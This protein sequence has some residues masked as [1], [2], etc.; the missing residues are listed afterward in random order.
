MMILM[1]TDLTGQEARGVRL[2]R[3]GDPVRFERLQELHEVTFEGYVQTSPS[4]LIGVIQSRPSELSVTRRLSRYY[5]TNLRRNPATPRVVLRLLDSIQRDLQNELRY[6]DPRVAEG[7]ST[8]LLEYLGQNGF[9]TATVGYRF[10]QDAAARVNRLTFVINEGPRAV[11]DTIIYLGMEDV[12]PDVLDRIRSNMTLKTGD[13]FSEAAF[14]QEIKNILVVLRNNGYFRARS[15]RPAIGISR[16]KLHDTLAVL[17]EPGTRCRIARIVFEENTNG[18]PS[19]NVSARRR[20]LEFEEGEWYSEEKIART[21]V[22]LMN[23]GAFEI[24]TIDTLARDTAVPDGQLN[25]DSTLTLR[26]FTRN[27]KVYDVGANLL[28]FQ[29]SIDNYLNGGGGATALYRNVFGG[30]QTASITLQ[31]VFQ[32]LSRLFQSQQLESEALASLNFGWPSFARIFD[33]RAALNLNVFYSQRNLIHPFRL[34]SAGLN[35]RLPLSLY[36]HTF[37]N[38]IDLTLGLERQVPR[39][40]QDALQTALKEATSVT[41]T[42]AVLQTFVQFSALDRYLSDERGFFT[43]TFFGISFRGEHRDNPVNPT[44]GT[45]TTLATE[46]GYG[47]GKFIRLQ[48]FNTTASPLRERL[49]AATKVRLGHIILLDQSQL[50]VPL[51]RQFF[52][53]GAASIRSYPSRQLHDTASGKL[54]IEDITSADQYVFA[55]I[56]GSASLLELSFE[57]RYTFPRPQ[58]I[59]DLWASLIERS[60]ITFFTDFGNAFNRLVPSAYGSARLEDF[61]IGSVMAAGFGYR[62]DT[63]VGPFRIDVGT[64]IYDPVRKNEAFIWNRQGALK[65]SN[66]QL[67]IGLGHAF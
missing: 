67:S 50:Y 24:A 30:A 2:E 57:L 14:D 6:Y 36:A 22:N 35:A 9:H 17:I 53:G 44:S 62:F 55:N 25:T 10:Q 16:D 45:F 28:M 34:E 65:L 4:Q 3:A 23:L 63:P 49:V 12:P 48:F 58:G 19:I 18:Q 43:G 40:F 5:L 39:N 33:Q 38:G 13:P 7:D 8:A 64:S 51:E 56:L 21:R 32:D 1:A 29:T 41:D 31:Y 66:F 26:V 20:Q 37:F 42:I 61:V 54:G 46:F 11:I 60:G 52:A 47:A 27:Q 15:G 59:D